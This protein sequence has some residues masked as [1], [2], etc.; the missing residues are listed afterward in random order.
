VNRSP[1]FLLIPF[2]VSLVGYLIT[3]FWFP[4]LPYVD[5]LPLPDIRSF[6]P[7]LAAGLVYG[8][9]LLLLYALYGLAALTIER[10]PQPPGLGWLLATAAL[11][12]LPQLWAFPIN[13]TDLYR[14][15]VRGRVFSI[16]GEN[17]FT[18]A[19]ATLPHDPFW[20]LAGEWATATSP[21]G[22]LW[23][24]TA[25][26]ITAV[27]QE[28]LVAGLLL[29]KLLGLLIHLA[30]GAL[31]WH[32]LGTVNRQRQASITL[33]WLWNPALFNIFVID[34]HN[35]GLMI[36][37]LLLGYL[38]WQRGERPL[39][40]FLLMVLAP[41]TKPIGLL[42]LPFFFLGMWHTVTA[43]NGRLL[44]ARLR[45][46]LLGISGSLLLVWLSFWPFGSP[47]D[48]AHRLLDEAAGGGFSPLTLLYLLLL[49]VM[50]TVPVNWL[51]NGARLLF[52]GAALLWLWWGWWAKRPSIRGVADI[53]TAYI[54]QA[55]SFRIWYAVWAFPWL[56]LDERPYWRRVGFW[57]LLTSQLSVLIYGH[58]RFY[59]LGGSLVWSHLVGVPFTFGLP[60]LLARWW[61]SDLVIG[62]W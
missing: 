17:P 24:L 52:I 13:A 35:D 25:A 37:W 48:L 57:F 30:N 61:R 41:L 26:G 3:P 5:Q 47:L 18:T 4:L 23:E 59:A 16:H 31:I 50:T 38:V 11:L 12:G 34:G 62:K 7:S 20:Q 36:F 40:A 1:R 14:Y 10:L 45:F 15:F 33:L 58:L 43:E 32:I 44:L 28:N 8:I 60:F 9:W 42:A 55:F 46:V 49:Q 27:V 54:W 39:L 2:A 51:L 21:Y 56:L 6:T 29:F 22:P 53:F 19:V